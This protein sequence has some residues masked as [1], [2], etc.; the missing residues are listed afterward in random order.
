MRGDPRN[1][2]KGVGKVVR[3]TVGQGSN[4][5]PPGIGL[6][7]SKS[8]KMEF[9]D[10]EHLMAKV[11]TVTS[12]QQSYVD[13]IAAMPEGEDST[14]EVSRKIGEALETISLKS[15]P[16]KTEVVVSGTNKRA[17]DMRDALT[18][19]PA[20][21][22]GNAVKVVESG[23]YL[24]MKISQSGHRDSVDLTVKHRI[25]KAW[26]KVAEVKA[27]INDARMGRL[28]WLRSG[29]TLIKAI[30]IPSL[31]YPA[32]V[33]LSMYKKTEKALRDA[34]KSMVY[35]ILDI[36]THTKWTSVLADL[37]IPNIMAVVDKLRINY[38]NHTMWGK[39][40]TKLRE[41]L[42]EEH[43][44]SPD[45]STLWE[46]D[47]LCAKYRI[48]KV[49][50]GPV[51]KALVKRWIREQDET[52]N[53]VSN[54]RSSVTQNVGLERV[55]ISTNF[56]KLPKRSSQALVAY[57]AGAFKLKTAWG[58]YHK[59]Q[60]CLAPMC[61]EKDE[62]DHIKSCPFYD[63]KWKE[64]YEKDVKQLATYFVEV[65]KERRRKWKGE[66]LF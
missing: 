43:R 54:V 59:V 12:D 6:T 21:M 46:A 5:A 47:L 22:Q 49:S 18:S 48:P 45:S 61:G 38:I 64:E 51:N 40:D 16:N 31:T 65:D 19:N 56:Y 8:V 14:R 36:T 34:Y 17:Q 20:V 7:S 1:D 28:G 30:I 4:F 60:D 66:C 50:E 42:V 2:G 23:M 13:D 27:V 26:G 9:K 37:G 11:G 39:G 33:W 32:D 35:M 63:T 25:A 15:H 10:S 58:S 3:G 53:W 29:V 44:L 55:R 41:F 52:E 24:G 62:L 57:H